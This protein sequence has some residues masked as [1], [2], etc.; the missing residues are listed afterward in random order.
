MKDE[1][2][3]KLLKGVKTLAV[4]DLQWGDTGKGKIV[5]YFAS[6]W[7][8]IVARGTGGDNA[9]HTIRRG[10]KE[11]VLHIMPCGIFSGKTSVIG[12]GTAVNPKA[13][14]EERIS[15]QGSGFD[16]SKLMVSYK[17]KLVLP[18]HRLL[19]SLREYMAG[20]SRI[21]STKK[22]MEPVYSDHSAR[23]GLI[24]N[25]LLNKDIFAN[26]LRR[27]LSEK[28]SLLR[29]FDSELVK[30]LMQSDILE[31]GIY[32]EPSRIFDEEAIM[33][34]YQVYAQV[35]QDCVW[36]TEEFMRIQAG[37]SKIL[38]EGSQGFLLS[39]DH[40]T[41]PFVTSSDCSLDG[42]L[43]GVGLNR[44]HLDRA[45]GIAKGAYVTRV[46]GGPMV[47][48]LGGSRSE[49]WCNSDSTNRAK[50]MALHGRADLNDPEDFMRGIAIR[51]VGNEYG[52]TTGRPRRIGWLDLPLLRYAL[53]HGGTD[54]VLT[55]MDVF[56]G[57]DKI[58]ICDAYEFVGPD[59]NYAGKKFKSGDRIF[60]AIPDAE[61]LKYCCPV[62]EELPG[63]QEDIRE[64]R[65]WEDLPLNLKS[66]VFRIAS[67][68]GSKPRIISVGPKPEETIYIP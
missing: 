58:K 12:S 63:W 62:Y 34:Q 47:T 26:K 31:N 35:F 42:L 43:K 68:T 29:N 66:L 37:T 11:H 9:G 56:D 32:Y 64:V 41:Y 54:M 16:T 51:R 5:D 19:D 49:A 14:S 39:I 24:I 10:N 45:L 17:A 33:C 36:D 44:A 50:E 13:L 55:K 40:G 18:T 65:S 8:D 28:K 7:A 25:D 59:M 46:G 23:F 4:V 6:G 3:S 67:R 21:G 38:L 30:K 15:A 52:A 57:C 27:H 1:L 61:F 20:S 60:C 48:E 22:G 2:E 53:A